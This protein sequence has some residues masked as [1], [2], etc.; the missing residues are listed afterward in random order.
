MEK[1][2]FK[3]LK[4]VISLVSL[5]ILTV[6]LFVITVS[7]EP[8]TTL[9][10]SPQSPSVGQSFSVKVRVRTDKA[11]YSATFEVHYNPDIL[12]Y[13]ST[14]AGMV[15]S[16]GAGIVRVAPSP[17]SSDFT[18]T[19]NFNAIAAGES[20]ISVNGTAFGPEEGVDDWKIEAGY[21][22]TV[23]D[24]SKSSNANLSALSLSSGRLS[25]SFS[26]SR[27]S[28]TATVSN[29][30]TE[31]RVYA[32]AADS[33]A[34]V[35]VSGSNT[36]SVGRNTR[37][38]TVTAP[39]G[40]Q[41]IYTITIIRLEEGA[42]SSDTDTSSD[43]E[44]A[45]ETG[46]NPYEATVDGAAYTVATDISGITL[47]TGFSASTAEYNGAE[48]AV[49][50]D[51]G[52]NLTVYYLKA[53]DSE[54][55]VPYLLNAESGDFERLKYAVFGD[56]TYIFADIPEGYTVPDGYYETDVKIGEFDLRAYADSGE[57]TPEFYY[58]YCFFDDG[59]RTYRYDSR[60]NVLQRCPEFQ[61]V[62]ENGEALSENAGLIERFNSLS[63]NAKVIVIGL[64]LAAAGAAALIVI[65][66][67][68]LVNSKNTLP[69]DDD[70]DL[71]LMFSDSFDS[72]NVSDGSVSEPEDDA[73]VDLPSDSGRH[74]GEN[75]ENRKE[76]PEED[77]NLN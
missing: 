4:R 25:P 19:F 28:Y 7:A 54:E 38:V 35:S 31:C 58:L 47:P 13:K 45:G 5:V 6:S 65:L 42:E 21:T 68:K 16:A 51:S 61:L 63:S 12:E 20:A 44:S 30:V 75:G 15:N 64:L 40:A 46:E 70:D 39:S 56:K 17:N 69:G 76:P 41:K 36:L 23:S 55:Y 52:R 18:Y 22:V 74:K 29:S 10:F 73:I 71:D 67:V 1:V 8:K 27:T 48:V 59:F 50:E 53:A 26:A 9:S 3:Y 2:M 77:D 57:E 37:T 43:T 24:A 14:D 11:A 62:P 49:A 33:G 66:I 34:S 72:V 32:T 60:E